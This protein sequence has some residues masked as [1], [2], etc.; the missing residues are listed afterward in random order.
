MDWR[1]PRVPQHAGVHRSCCE[2][3]GSCFRAPAIWH[4]HQNPAGRTAHRQNPGGGQRESGQGSV[5]TQNHKRK[6]EQ[7][8]VNTLNSP[9]QVRVHPVRAEQSSLGPPEGATAPQS[10]C[11]RC[12]GSCINEEFH[13]HR[14]V[15]LHSRLSAVDH[16]HTSPHWIL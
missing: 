15:Y 9:V 5:M 6:S 16:I 2:A 14:G 7:A 12:P 8:D 10:S 1:Q 3:P 11:G 13:Y 4:G